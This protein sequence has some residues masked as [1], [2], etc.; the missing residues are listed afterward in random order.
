MLDT[1]SLFSSLMP[2]TSFSSSRSAFLPFTELFP[3]WSLQSKIVPYLLSSHTHTPNETSCAST[4]QASAVLPSL[5][6]S[7]CVYHS[8][9]THTQKKKIDIN[10]CLSRKPAVR[11][12]P[13]KTGRSRKVWTEQASQTSMPEI[14]QKSPAKL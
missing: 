11:A 12:N 4:L 14:D 2:K 8:Y 1:T 7:S 6:Y 13:S 3:A 9:T 5:C 10:A